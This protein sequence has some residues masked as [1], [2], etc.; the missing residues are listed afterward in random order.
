[1]PRLPTTPESF[2][3]IIAE[4]GYI[5]LS[6]LETIKNTKSFVTVKCPFG[7]SEYLVSVNNFKRGKRCYQCGRIR[8]GDKKRLSIEAIYTRFQSEGYLLKSQRYTDSHQILD[9]ICPLGHVWKTN[10]NNFD[11]GTRCASCDPRLPYTTLFVRAV[12][13]KAGYTLLSEDYINCYTHV[14]IRCPMGHKRPI[15][16]SN[17][18]QGF[19]CGG[20]A[21]QTSR[22]ELEILS[23]ASTLTDA[24]G[25]DRSILGS[26]ELD[27]WCPKERVGVEYNGLF[28]HSEAGKKDKN[29]HLN[30]L[31]MAESANIRLLQFFEDE[32]RDKRQLVESIIVRSLKQN[33]DIRIGA[34]KLEL[35][36]APVKERR[37]FFES[38]HLQGDV[39]SEMAWGL[40]SGDILMQTLSIR[41]NSLTGSSSFYDIAR[42]ATRKGYSVAGG[43]SRLL[44][45]AKEYLK[46]KDVKF[47]HTY[48]DR[49]YSLGEAYLSVGF[50]ALGATEPGY[51]YT[52]GKSRVHRFNLKRSRGCPEGMSNDDFRSSQGW[53]KI[54]DCGQLKF[55]IPT[56]A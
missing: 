37:L 36:V 15:L 9:V 29:T 4:A 44:F 48:A 40:Y 54:W 34:R 46:N 53:S 18:Q 20:C 32:W 30:K 52:D 45:K 27:I 31:K 17:F 21:N 47:L 8:A 5:L 49:R 56:G 10:Y 6:K 19:R 55:R 3:R 22:A 28:W 23:F 7:H 16:F 33:K 12:L 41:K 2:A 42:L 11:Q 25:G 38:N 43:L 35:K 26:H 51:F 1:M 13:E 14:K 39:P 50:E 24:V